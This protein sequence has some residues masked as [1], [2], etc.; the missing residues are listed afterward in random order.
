MVALDED[1]AHAVVQMAISDKQVNVSQ[2][3]LVVVSE[4]QYL[5]SMKGKEI[6]AL[7]TSLYPLLGTDRGKKKERK[8][9]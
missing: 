2:H 9:R 5:Q 1:T 4:T 6:L 8:E 7:M 3:M